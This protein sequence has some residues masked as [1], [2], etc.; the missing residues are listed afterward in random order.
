MSEIKRKIY[1]I[2]GII[3]FCLGMIGWKPK[4]FWESSLVEIYAAISGFQEF[5]TVTKD[6]P[7]T[8]E[9]LDE[10]MELYPD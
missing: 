7:M 3:F 6:A 8:T 10:L 5:H 2:F 4:T 1:F 9:E